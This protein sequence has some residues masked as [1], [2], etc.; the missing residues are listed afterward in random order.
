MKLKEKEKD[1][2][3]NEGNKKKKTKNWL[4]V[5]GNQRNTSTCYC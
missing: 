3:K 4:K 2:G 1:Q 5:L